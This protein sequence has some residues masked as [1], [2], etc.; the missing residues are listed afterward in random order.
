MVLD[1]ATYECAS[2]IAWGREQT[3]WLRRVSTIQ[4]MAM[5]GTGAGALSHGVNVAGDPA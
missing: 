5:G 1:A 3:D 4:G 2:R